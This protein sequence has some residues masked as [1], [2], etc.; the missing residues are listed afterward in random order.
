MAVVAVAG[1]LV[2]PFWRYDTR[3]AAPDRLPR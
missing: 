2:R 1:V 3:T